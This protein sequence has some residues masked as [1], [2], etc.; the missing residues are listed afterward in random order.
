MEII[1][2]ELSLHGQYL[3][4]ND[5]AERGL[6]PLAEI[7]RK[8]VNDNGISILKNHDFYNAKVYSDTR[9]HEIMYHVE[10]R[11]NERLRQFKSYLARFQ[12]KPYWNEDQR[13]RRGYDYQ[14]V[15]GDRPITVT[16]HDLA[17]AYARD[18]SVISFAPSEY[19]TE[20]IEIACKELD[21]IKSIDN[22]RNHRHLLSVRYKKGEINPLVE[23]N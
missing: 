8:I 20:L 22:I 15:N 9:L 6:T 11:R 4:L 10:F 19:E 3:G 17:E 7:F 12:N 16:G 23:L 14:I 5:F 1:L 2:N 13:H 18:A 21:V